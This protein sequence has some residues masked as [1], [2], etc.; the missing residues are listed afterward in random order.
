[1]HY[2]LNHQKENL[3]FLKYTFASLKMGGIQVILATQTCMH[4]CNDL[5][6]CAYSI[7]HE[8]LSELT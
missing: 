1:M 4:S 3:A 6:A 5:H 7:M 8:I 2:M